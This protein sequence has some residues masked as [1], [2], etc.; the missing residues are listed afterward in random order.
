M[1]KE[2]CDCADY[3]IHGNC[4]HVRKTIKPIIFTLQ[5]TEKLEKLA[6]EMND[7][8][9]KYVWEKEGILMI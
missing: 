8:I 7:Y 4:I 6:K 2:I 9:N 1:T 3:L 5:Q